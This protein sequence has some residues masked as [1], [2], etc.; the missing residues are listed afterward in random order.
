MTF[1]PVYMKP[2]SIPRLPS[3]S[4]EYSDYITDES[5]LTDADL[6]I[7][8]LVYFNG[9]QLRDRKWLSTSFRGQLTGMITKR[10]SVYR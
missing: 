10:S 3:A 8:A 7:E 4:V 1:R 2:I 6:L 5:I 9:G